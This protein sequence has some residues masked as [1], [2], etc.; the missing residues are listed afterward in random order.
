MD[1][2][3]CKAFVKVIER[4]SITLAAKE[5]GYSQPGISHMMDA[6]ERE[7]GFPLFVRSKHQIIPTP[8]G[9][10]LLFH[11]RN[12]VKSSEQF[13]ETV[14]SIN[15]L[16][17]GSI[18][19][20]SYH[21][22]LKEY[23]PQLILEFHTAFKNI[24]INVIEF[25]SPELNSSLTSNESDMGFMCN[26]IPPDF[27]F[28]PLL[29]DHYC[30]IMNEHHP[31]A[32]YDTVPLKLLNGCNLITPQ[33]GWDEIVQE[34]L[35][36]ANIDNYKTDYHISSDVGSVALAAKGLGIFVTSELQ[37]SL[38]PRGAIVRRLDTELHRTIGL[39]VR[40]LKNASPAAKEFIKFAIARADYHGTCK[41]KAKSRSK[42]ETAD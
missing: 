18:T 23:L 14:M 27:E 41:T 37:T 16:L 21:T 13:E 29:D 36:A 20:G 30:I 24:G 39:A 12:I 7:V 15:G 40:S 26:P 32:A 25:A 4:Q 35:A 22:P 38:L 17:K 1:L 11:A 2:L 19:I 33:N 28:Y 31:L 10:E 9:K 5:M 34:V 8:A 6:L 42:R 3:K